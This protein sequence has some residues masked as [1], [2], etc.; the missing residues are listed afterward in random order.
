MIV[1]ITN[2]CLQKNWPRFKKRM[3]QFVEVIRVTLPL[4]RN[5][6]GNGDLIYRVE[7][8]R[9]AE[10]TLERLDRTT[11]NRLRDRLKEISLDPYSARL[12]KSLVMGEG[13]FSSRVGD[14]RIIYLVSEP[15]KA[16]LVEAIHSRQKA[17]K[18]IVK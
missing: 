16:V 6:K 3:R 8:S 17:Y 1:T 13:K 12:G 18:K 2:L 10:K 14:W 5:T 11:E 4:W 15:E 9:Q 7:L